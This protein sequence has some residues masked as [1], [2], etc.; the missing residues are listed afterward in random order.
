MGLDINSVQFLLAAQKQGV[1]FDH[2]LMLGRHSMNVFPRTLKAVM[3]LRKSLGFQRL[4]LLWHQSD[5]NG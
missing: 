5:R 1:R 3:E 2:T 4:P